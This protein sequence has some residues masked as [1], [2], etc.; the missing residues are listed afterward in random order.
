MANEFTLEEALAPPPKAASKAAPKEF[1]LAE[2]LAA[3]AAS[4]AAQN[5]A[6]AQARQD[7]ASKGEEQVSIPQAEL[8]EAEGNVAAL[9][10]ELTRKGA[11]A[12]PR[13]AIGSTKAGDFLLAQGAQAQ[14]Q[15]P[16]PAPAVAVTPAPPPAVAVTPAPP[17]ALALTPPKPQVATAAP[18]NA[19][20]GADDAWAAIN[21]AAAA[22]ASQL[23]AL[24]R[25]P[26]LA[27][28]PTD[29]VAVARA[30]IP[31]GASPQFIESMRA[32]LYQLSPEKRAA[33][34]QQV[35]K[36][37][38][39]DSLKGRV[40]SY[41][42]AENAA[43]DKI[44]KTPSAPQSGLAKAL[45][46][47]QE[48]PIY[49]SL[50]VPRLSPRV[51]DIAANIQAEYPE[52][53]YELILQD[54]QRAIDFGYLNAR[55]GS[56]RALTKEQSDA[57]DIAA[58]A[59]ANAE[60]SKK[61]SYGD[62]GASNFGGG[63]SDVALA[64][65]QSVTDAFG[66]TDKT[67]QLAATRKSIQ[68]FMQQHGGDTT[69]GKVMSATGAITPAVAE[70]LAIP[71]TGGGS[72]IPLLSSGILYGLPG[73]KETLAEQLKSGA[74]VD[75]ALEHALAAGGMMV[76]GGR[77]VS[78]GGKVLPQALKAGDRLL[79]QMTAA[80]A[81]GTAFY[82]A[83]KGLQKTISGMNQFFGQ[84][85]TVE[86]PFSL[87]EMVTTAL[88]MALA[89]GAHVGVSNLQGKAAADARIPYAKDDSYAGLAQRI[90]EAKGFNFKPAEPA[91][92]KVTAAPVSAEPALGKPLAEAATT[93]RAE[94]GLGNL[95]NVQAG[96]EPSF[97]KGEAASVTE[98]APAAEVA[99]SEKAIAEKLQAQGIPGP[100]ARRMAKKQVEEQGAKD[101]AGT[102]P[103]PSGESTSVASESRVEPAAGFETPARDGVVPVEPNAGVSDAGKAPEPAA[104]TETETKGKPSGTETVE[105][106]QTEAQEQEAPATVGFR[107]LGEG[108]KGI[109]WISTKEILDLG[110]GNKVQFGSNGDGHIG[111]KDDAD[112]SVIRLR[113]T[114]GGVTNKLSNFPDFVPESLRQPLLDYS[115]ALED[116]YY[117]R[118][119]KSKAAEDAARA[120]VEQAAAA[121]NPK[122]E[123]KVEE[124]KVRKTE[125]VVNENGAFIPA[126]E[127]GGELETTAHFKVLD[128]DNDISDN[129]VGATMITGMG[130]TK[131]G[132]G[133][134]SKLLK[135]ITAWAD[136]NGK[137]L[138]LV[139]AAT[140]KG[141]RGLSQEQLKAWYAR[142]GFEDRIDYMVREPG[143]KKA[144]APAA[145]KPPKASKPGKEKHTVAQNTEGKWEHAINGEVANTYDTKRQAIAAELLNKAKKAG[146]AENIAQRQKAFDDAMAAE[147]RGRPLK[148]V[149]TTDRESLQTLKEL[150]SALETYNSPDSTKR[151]INNSAG[152]IRDIANDSTSSPAVQK[153]A[154]KMLDEEIDPKDIPKSSGS[155]SIQASEGVKDLA[156]SNFTTS[157]QT[158]SHIV[159]TGTAFQKKLAQRLRNV[160]R[161]VRMVVI[162]KGQE[163]PAT[164]AAAKDKWDQCLALYSSEGD[165]V[166]YTKGESFGRANGLNKVVQSHELLHAATSQ[167]IRTAL[168]YMSKGRHLD[169]QM[170]QSIK[171]LQKTMRAAAI[172]LNKQIADGTVD[173][174]LYGLAHSGEA[175]TNLH[176]FVSYSMSD[177][178]MQDF[179]KAVEG[180]EKNT[181]LFSPFVDSVRRMFG[182][183]EKDV[184]ALSDLIQHTDQLLSSRRPGGWGFP[185]AETFASAAIPPTPEE[186]EKEVKKATDAVKTGR[187]G[188][189]LGNA[190]SNLARLRDPVLYGMKSKG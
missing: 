125:P 164:L 111:N 163:L 67:K 86:H 10:R 12:G 14:G 122:P 78:T 90:A 169:S 139:P 25:A 63:L 176:E 38:G 137:K 161:D 26:R 50:P 85:D 186:R 174:H 119:E 152:Y 54:A 127:K 6:D 146:N 187:V 100:L 96:E 150:E 170:V 190:T 9:R 29:A 1:T 109:P 62:I 104:L 95:E 52:R 15:K 13:P 57:M 102:E 103:P 172:E 28:K 23:S 99:P 179:L 55:Y 79:P 46:L 87:E 84:E 180:Y 56:M 94:P 76:I 175:F 32:E 71:F 177:S 166:V 149:E 92:G 11:D 48:T 30:A 148:P 120:K 36:D 60:R 158:L 53:P 183:G 27:A 77:L 51:E 184:N 185:E 113:D 128:E 156:F 33:A 181:Q 171:G 66:A 167:K 97:G 89:R 37:Y 80:A 49:S 74:S 132:Q 39:K 114:R 93:N 160:V 142:N 34:I 91:L 24:E 20:S 112:I 81:E 182:M 129:L 70:G 188:Y 126:K 162:E 154:Q 133:E 65:A 153:R 173:P 123:T 107:S 140:P 47:K 43:F 98:A 35:I 108:E 147:G 42:A 106:K 101:V 131:E 105:A 68:L 145:P 83:D 159:K 136:A 17:P 121:L 130:A 72:L 157:S 143:G 116:N 4:T 110:N 141:E 73:F 178:K 75:V 44:Y 88:S 135:A 2:A 165:G 58:E 144:E 7:A 41:I 8:A 61:L 59:K 18:V 69:F 155:L 82:A 138:V 64:G 40:A 115:K 22:P 134:G 5:R 124:P 189:E 3:P 118:N 117:D 19:V 31:L 168:A 21:D 16:A 45:G 151:Q